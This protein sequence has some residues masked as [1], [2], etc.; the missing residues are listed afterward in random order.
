MHEDDI[1]DV[2]VVALTE[3]KIQDEIVDLTGPAYDAPA[4]VK[5]MQDQTAKGDAQ[6]YVVLAT[7]PVGAGSAA[8]EATRSSERIVKIAVVRPSPIAPPAT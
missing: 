2:A 6:V 3:K 7:D 5:A 1:A 8:A 4:L